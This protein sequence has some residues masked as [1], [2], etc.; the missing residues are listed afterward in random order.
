[1]ALVTV[2]M[3]VYN[4]APYL[5]EA[6]DSI[7]RQSFKNFEFLIIND[8]S[9]DN[10]EDI[11]LAY[12]DERIRYFKNEGNIKL[13]ATLNKG[14]ALSNGKYI[15][16]MDADDF[17]L[18][19][20]LERQFS[21]LEKNQNIIVAGSWYSY[22]GDI[23]RTTQYPIL[24]EEIKIEMLYRCPI[25]HPSVMWRVNNEVKVRF[26]ADYLHAEDYDLWSRLI[27]LGDIANIPEVLLNY[28]V[29]Q[30]SV[31]R[32]NQVKQLENSIRV[33]QNQFEKMGIKLTAS[34]CNSYAEFCY[35]NWS[36]FN[37]KEL[38]ENLGHLINAI[39][40]ANK[41]SKY[42]TP[43]VFDNYIL[44]KWYHLNY[45]CGEES[46]FYT[47]SVEYNVSLKDRLKLKIKSLMKK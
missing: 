21:F 43:S 41:K 11:I 39:L 47:L 42:I 26:C 40:V 24:H 15:A 34:E 17:A 8:G 22:I 9:T 5:N 44:S 13:I 1:M 30:E 28:R 3:P 7:L 19:H 16:R 35:A 10:S 27:V 32:S 23:Q 6:I 18:P 33:R 31:S 37:K 2:L 45:N 4:A 14:I 20:R 36:F 12:K 29:H 38:V 25:C 46:L